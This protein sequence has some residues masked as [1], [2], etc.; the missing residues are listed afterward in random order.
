MLE[1]D[2]WLTRFLDVRYPHLPAEQQ[3]VFARLLE[4][5][6]MQLFDWL[7]GEQAPPPEF[8]GV[9]EIIKITRTPQQ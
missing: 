2:A 3:A 1:L 5:D 8:A 4:Q 7:T 6:D 9:V